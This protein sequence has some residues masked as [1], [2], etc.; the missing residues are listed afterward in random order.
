MYALGHVVGF[1][2]GNLWVIAVAA[3]ATVFT[4]RHVKR[5]NQEREWIKGLWRKLEGKQDNYE[6]KRGK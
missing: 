5:K 4:V 6:R 1:L 3:V 2:L